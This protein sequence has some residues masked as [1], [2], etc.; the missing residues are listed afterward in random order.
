MKL[1]PSPIFVW[2]VYSVVKPTAVFHS[3]SLRPLRASVQIPVLFIL[4]AEQKAAKS[5]GGSIRLSTLNLEL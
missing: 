5:F 4:E 2:F 3:A 1:F